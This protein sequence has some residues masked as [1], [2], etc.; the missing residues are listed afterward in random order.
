MRRKEKQITDTAA[1]RSILDRAI[2]CRIAI[3]DGNRPY[4]LP[5]SFGVDGDCVYLHCANEGRKLDLINKNPNV[6]LEFETD[7]E[8]VPS[9]NN[10][11]ISMRFKSAIAFGVAVIVEDPEEKITGLGSIIKHYGFIPNEYPEHVLDRTTV[12]RV[13]I[14]EITGKQS[15]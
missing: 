1:I 3:C 11:G 12:I 13:D 10:C 6:C 2:V 4:V 14:Q 9:E 15:I 5:I 8:L 7:V